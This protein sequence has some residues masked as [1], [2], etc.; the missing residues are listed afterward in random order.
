MPKS[1][2]V[3]MTTAMESRIFSVSPPVFPMRDFP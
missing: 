2:A 3:P 1:L